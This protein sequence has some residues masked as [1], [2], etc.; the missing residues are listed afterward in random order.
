VVK[1]SDSAGMECV[2]VKNVRSR[3]ARICCGK[4]TSDSAW[5]ECVMIQIVRLSMAEMCHGQNDRF[6]MAGMCLGKKRKNQHAWVGTVH[7]NLLKLSGKETET[8]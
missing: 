2:V 6:S 7:S 8:N 3:M 5:L 4:Q 1:K